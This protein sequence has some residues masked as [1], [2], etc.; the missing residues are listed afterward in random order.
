AMP[1]PPEPTG[2]DEGPTSIST[3]EA[4]VEVAPSQT[5][6]T[7]NTSAL[8]HAPD[9]APVARVQ[10]IAPFQHVS[11]FMKSSDWQN[12][13]SDS[14]GLKVCA[15]S[16]SAEKTVEIADP[17]PLAMLNEAAL[18]WGRASQWAIVNGE[19]ASFPVCTFV[20]A[21]FGR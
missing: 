21:R 3:V 12:L 14:V 19:D 5:A 16:A 11:E 4:R 10:R 20:I 8:T 6:E 7:A 2:A 18:A 17:S 13:K 9:F 1:S 15:P